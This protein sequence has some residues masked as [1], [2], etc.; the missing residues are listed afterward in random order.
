MLGRAGGRRLPIC[1]VAGWQPARVAGALNHRVRLEPSVA[2]ADC[3]SATQPTASRRH[4]PAGGEMTKNGRF[5]RDSLQN[6]KK[7]PKSFKMNYLYGVTTV[8]S[9]FFVGKP[10]SFNFTRV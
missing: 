4:I 9:G 7:S 5:R 3:Q 1:C 10:Y 8:I 6:H 2:F